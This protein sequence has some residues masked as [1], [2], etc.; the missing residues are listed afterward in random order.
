MEKKDYQVVS[1]PSISNKAEAN[2]DTRQSIIDKKLKKVSK[3][4]I[5]AVHSGPNS[6]KGSIANQPS[7]TVD[8][9]TNDPERVQDLQAKI[10]KTKKEAQEK[11]TEYTKKC[12]EIE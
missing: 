2:E 3:L 5:A 11:Q 7:T 9:S 1:K 4:H 6:R 10:G 12:I 8:S